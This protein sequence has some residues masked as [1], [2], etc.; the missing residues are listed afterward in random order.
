MKYQ[1]KLRDVRKKTCAV[2]VHPHARLLR[3]R[4]SMADSFDG[5]DAWTDRGF[6]WGRR[7]LN[8]HASRH[9]IL[10]HACLPVPALPRHDCYARYYTVKSI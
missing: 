1:H 9:M 4:S 3:F 5:S 2:G 6:E 10:S 8:P 7:D